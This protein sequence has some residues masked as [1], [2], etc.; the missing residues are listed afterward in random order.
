MFKLPAQGTQEDALFEQL[1]TYRQNDLKWRGGKAFGYVYNAGKKAEM[2]GKRAF[3][4][5]LSENGL[6]PTAFPS[7]MRLENEVMALA[8]GHLGGAESTVG[9]F[10]SGGTE[11]IMLA[12]K[13]AREWAKIHKPHTETPE[14]ILPTTAHAA[15]HK[16]AHYLGLK[17]INV[18]VNPETMRA[19][20]SAMK[21]AINDN[22]VLMVGSSPSYAHGVVDPI[23]ELAG[24]AKDAGLLFHVDACVGGWLLPFFKRLG[25]DVP[26]FDF[27][28]PGVTSISMD[29]HKYAF[30]PKGASV[31]LY[32]RPELRQHH[33][34][35]CDEW[36]GYTIINMAVQSS[37]SGG[38][39]AAA[40]AVL[41]GLG[42]EGYMELAQ[43][44]LD[45]T[46]A[47]K[48]G[49]AAIDGLDIVSRPDFCM[50][51]FTSS[52]A[53]VFHI[54]DEMSERGWYIQP[55]FAFGENH[56]ENIHISISPGN[57][58]LVEPFLQALAE[59]VEAAKALPSGQM[60][61]ML[62]GQIGAMNPSDL[63]PE[64]IEGFMGMLG[65]QGAS[66]PERMA[67]INEVLNILPPKLKEPMLIT[68]MG[69]LF[70]PSKG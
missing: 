38:P 65:V 54:A 34:F 48:E 55:Q 24:I 61:A 70:R 42:D 44:V 22:T 28:V 19:V 49:I 51:A 5:Y 26:A 17:L 13:S 45:A 10:T 27:S 32:A 11:S 31:I 2:I 69:Q 8:A 30:T 43:S 7:L 52:Q 62:E 47:I 18:P 4:M 9:T 58:H 21:A 56:K 66:L 16:A 41:N 25:A 20:P 1:E 46:A 37:K 53:S 23:E 57:A 68:F 14:M 60:A 64:V 40:W 63:G 39:L 29:L 3:A 6:D 50:L 12:D 36:T 59:S 35:A 67:T 33:A 15:F